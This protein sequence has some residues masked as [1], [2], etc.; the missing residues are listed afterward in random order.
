ML[1]NGAPFPPVII[2][3]AKHGS[4]T[5]P[6]LLQVTCGG[7]DPEARQWKVASRPSRIRSSC[8]DTLSTGADATNSHIL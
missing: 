3:I 4:L 8:G 1:Q 6:T 5:P 7:R 2:L